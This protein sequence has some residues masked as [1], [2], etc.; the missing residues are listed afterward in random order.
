[1]PGPDEASKS[2]RISGAQADLALVYPWL[3]D[4]VAPY[5]LSA[6]IRHAMHV[7]LEEAVINVATHNLQPDSQA[8]IVVRFCIDQGR[9]VLV[10]ED[11]GLPFDP[12]L[13]PEKPPATSLSEAEPGGLGLKLLRHYCKDI[14]YTRT[15]ELNRLTLRF[16]R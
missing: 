12:V 4:A 14:S 15:D 3:D 10:V 5:G 6:Q 9:A 16:P 8:K 13:A 7:A 11:A 1:V 2:L